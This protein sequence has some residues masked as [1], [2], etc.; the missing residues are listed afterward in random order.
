MKDK[1]IVDK[2]G[3]PLPWYSYSAICF[4][5]ERLLPDMKIFEYGSGYSTAFY[6]KIVAEVNFVEDDIKWYNYVMKRW[7]DGS[8]YGVCCSEKDDYLEACNTGKT[9]DI[10][11]IDGKWRLERI[12]PAIRCLNEKSVIILDD[13]EA[14][15]LTQTREKLKRSGS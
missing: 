6:S 7:G 2:Q 3:N 9:Y 11:V 8:I 13:T 10:I 15:Y 14:T 5:K 12:E 4:L 1:E